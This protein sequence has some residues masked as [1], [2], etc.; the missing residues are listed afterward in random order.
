MARD[1]QIGKNLNCADPLF[2]DNIEHTAATEREKVKG[3]KICSALLR[4]QSLPDKGMKVLQM[5]SALTM[6]RQWEDMCLAP[7]DMRRPSDLFIANM[8]K[9]RKKNS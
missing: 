1:S 6:S 5:P 2:T 9:L 7:I 8:N 4:V 3:K